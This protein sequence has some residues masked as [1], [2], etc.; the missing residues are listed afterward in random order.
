MFD[1]IK[2]VFG[3]GEPDPGD[4]TSASG[5]ARGAGKAD[6]QIAP[7]QMIFLKSA[8]L[9]LPSLTPLQIKNLLNIPERLQI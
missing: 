2:K 6:P 5:P 1:G 4:I 8:K 7:W 3:L 9:D